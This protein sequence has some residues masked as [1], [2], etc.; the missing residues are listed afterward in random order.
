MG[1][2]KAPGEHEWKGEDDKRTVHVR[3][4][5]DYRA[6][7]LNGDIEP[8]TKLPSTQ[9]MRAAYSASVTAVQNAMQILKDEGL[10]VSQAGAGI[11]VREHRAR[12]IRPSASLAPAKPG[13]TYPWIADAQRQGMTAESELLEVAEV[14]PPLSVARALGIEPGQTALMRRQL[15]K[16]DGEPAE[17]VENYYPVEI[18]RGTAIEVARKVKGGVPRLLADLGY[19]PR[20]AEDVVSAQVPT[21]EQGAYLRMPTGE[22]PILHTFRVVRSDDD[23][24]IEVSVLAKAGHMYKLGYKLPIS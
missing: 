1:M 16:L 18:A 4:A 10:V 21:P 13:E 22:L 2:R 5:A 3:I 11:W 20:E 24:V 8:G 15:L 14:E 12:V 19:P 9:A 7:I 17:L 23:R 6:K